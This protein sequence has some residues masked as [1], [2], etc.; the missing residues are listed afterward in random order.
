M[1]IV[2]A[3]NVVFA[4]VAMAA[5]EPAACKVIVQPEVQ[6]TLKVPLKLGYQLGIPARDN[7]AFY[8]ECFSTDALQSEIARLNERVEIGLLVSHSVN[9]DNGEITVVQKNESSEFKGIT[10]RTGYLLQGKSY[11]ARVNG[12]RLLGE[13]GV[14]LRVRHEH[15][16]EILSEQ[17]EKVSRWSKER[18]LEWTITPRMSGFYQFSFMIHPGSSMKLRGFSLLPEESISIWR[19]ESIDVL[20]SAGAGT[21]RWPVVEGMDFYNWYD[22]I[23]ARSTRTP[24]Q[25]EKTGLNH[26]DFGTAEYVDFC[27]VVGVEPLICV[28]LYT[29]GCSD[30]RVKDLNAA[31]RIAADWV[32]YCNAD[33]DHPL[34]ALR[35]KNGLGEPL[36]VKH[37]ELTAPPAGPLLSAE[38]IASACL[39]TINAMKEEDSDILVGVTLKDQSVQTLELLLKKAGSRMDFVSCGASGAF[40]AVEKYNQANGGKVML[41]ATELKADYGDYAARVLEGFES[42]SGKAREYYGNWYHSLGLA[43]AAVSRVGGVLDGPVCLPYYAEQVLGLDHGS[44]RLSTDIG[45]LSAMIGRFPAVQ[46]LK[47]EMRSGGVVVKHLTFDSTLSSQAPSGNSQMSKCSATTP[48][49]DAPNFYPAW[50]EDGEVLVVFAYNPAPVARDVVLDVSHLKK[51]FS[52]WIMDQLSADMKA[53]RKGESVP[54]LRNQKA[55]AAVDKLIEF[56]LGAASF[57]RILVKE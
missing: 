54:V 50:A 20:R 39:H 44:T 53:K 36:R 17:E 7:S 42:G 23:G 28:P 38:M 56:P 24:V 25:P 13:R 51:N 30:S 57:S 19:R 40:A 34:A 48:C 37:W 21:F 35:E 31:S 18:E 8:A 43:N 4:F 12:E 52:F 41:A 47:H 45:L 1:K 14:K 22:G 16:R 32:A 5:E 15:S 2:L 46:P 33:D 10:L 9:P 3:F 49:M 27:R 26:H 6:G 55:G 11:I 29:P